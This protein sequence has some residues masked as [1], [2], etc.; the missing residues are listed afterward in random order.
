M[1]R[2]LFRRSAPFPLVLGCNRPLVGVD[3]EG[4]Q[5]VQETPHLLVLLT[6]HT[7]RAPYQLSEYH[8]LRQSRILHNV[9]YLC[10][11]GVQYLLIPINSQITLTTLYGIIAATSLLQSIRTIAA[12]SLLYKYLHLKISLGFFL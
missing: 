8:A 12:S 7:A 3:A 10:R 4:S 1:S 6:P 9:F 2:P 5:V 11:L